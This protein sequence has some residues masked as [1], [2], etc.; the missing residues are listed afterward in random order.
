L[1]LLLLP[2]VDEVVVDHVA[3]S[4]DVAV[5]VVLWLFVVVIVVVVQQEQRQSGIL[6][7]KEYRIVGLS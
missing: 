5:V 6:L 1:L 7:L 4:V 2:V 3:V